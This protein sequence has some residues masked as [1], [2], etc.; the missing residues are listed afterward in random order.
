MHATYPRQLIFKTGCLFFSVLLMHLFALC[1][2]CWLVKVNYYRVLSV[3]YLLLCTF[4]HFL[5]DLRKTTKS[6]PWLRRMLSAKPFSNILH[7][8]V[9]CCYANL[10]M[11]KFTTCISNQGFVPRFILA[12]YSDVNM[13]NKVFVSLLLLL[14]VVS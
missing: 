10:F 11:I 8:R 14:S 7:F 4:E 3:I 12:T 13:H 2:H 6:C 9:I 1:K 5:W